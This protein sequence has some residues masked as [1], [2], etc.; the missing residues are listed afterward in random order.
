MAL[1]HRREGQDQPQ[2]RKA[3]AAARTQNNDVEEQQQEGND[4]A[5]D[6]RQESEHGLYQRGKGSQ[7]PIVPRL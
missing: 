5:H 2:H 1:P 6:G 4:A 3:P 7:H